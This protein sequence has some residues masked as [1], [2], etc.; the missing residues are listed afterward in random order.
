MHALLLAGLAAAR[1]LPTPLA[2]GIGSELVPNVGLGKRIAHDDAQVVVWYGGEQEGEL[3]PCGC[4]AAPAGGVA[5][6]GGWV[7]ANREALE[8]RPSILV[9]PGGWLT[10]TLAADGVSFRSD[11]QVKNQAMVEALAQWD[12][13][14]VSFRDLPWLDEHGFPRN[15]VSANLRT[16]VGDGPVAFRTIERGGLKI[17]ITGVTAQGLNR[18]QPARF[19]WSD[20]VE[21]LWKLLPGIEADLVVVLAYDTRSLTDDLA[22][23]PGVDLVVET[24]EFAQFDPATREGEALW[25]RGWR[26]T[27]R[28]G[29]LRLKLSEG[30]ITSAFDRSV[31]LD[32]KV[33]KDPQLAD[34][35]RRTG[36]KVASVQQALR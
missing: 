8:G 14:N 18:L 19:T 29:E 11:T 36:Q 10:T 5:R 12:A 32:N 27:E 25:A 4:S 3:G 35:E 7:E 28:L 13:L 20:P 22:R 1:P 21:A 17:A 16:S 24:G 9:N 26:K 33:P 2:E 6:V 31:P 23:V 34:L 30:R 15:A